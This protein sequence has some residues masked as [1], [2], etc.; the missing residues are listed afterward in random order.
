MT[1][2]EI[3]AKKTEI[4]K[5]IAESDVLQISSLPSRDERNL[6]GRLEKLLI[7]TPLKSLSVNELENILKV[8][9]NINN[10]YLPHYTQVVVE[11]LN[12]INNTENLS[13][14]ID[15]AKPLP[16]TSMYARLKSII[17]KKGSIQE[18][19]RRNPL[20]Y[21]DQVFGNFKTKNI[22]DSVFGM[23]SEEVSKFRSGLKNIQDRITKAEQAVINSFDKDGNKFVLSKY[24]QMAYMIQEEFLSNPDSKQVN[25]VSDFL[26]AT[27]TRIDEDTTSYTKRDADML[28][29]IVDTYTDANGDFDNQALY[30]SF[31]DAEKKS[32]KTLQDINLE[33]GPKAVYTASIIRGDKIKPLENYVHLNVISDTTNM[34]AMAAPSF[35]ES[36]NNSLR[37]STKAKSLIE[38]TGKVSPLNF[39]VYSSVQKGAKFVLMDYHLTEPIRT[40]RR[41]LNQTEK[42]LTKNGRIDSDKRKVFNAIKNGFEEATLNLLDNSFTETSIMDNALSYIK[43]QGYRAILSSG[44]RFIAELTSNVSFALI[45][46]PKGFMSGVKLRGFITSPEA[47]QAMNNLNSV[48][49]NRIFPNDS[50]SGRMVDTNGFNEAKGTK[51]GKA[52]SSV[53]NYISKLWNKTGQRWVNGVELTADVLISTPDKLIMRPMWFGAFDNRFKDLTGKSPDFDKIAQNDEAYMEANKDALKQATELA[54]KRSVMAGATDNAFMGMLKGTS[55]PNQKISI[56]A[57]NAFNNFMTRFL[58]FEYITARSG[59]MSMIGRGEMSKKQGGAV[60]GAVMSRMVLYT[61]IG[62]ILAE[63]LTGMFDGDDEE[64]KSEDS[65][66]KNKSFEK[67]LGQSFASAFSS[68]LF[69]RDFGNATKGIINLGVE[70]FNQQQL[71]FLRDGDYD[72]YKDAIQYT[73]AP[74]ERQGKQT[75]LGDVLMKLGAAYGPVLRTADLIVRKATEPDKKEADAI[76]R[77]EDEKYV[78][79]PLEILGNLG[80]IPMYK[81]IRKVVLQNMYKDLEKAQRTAKDKKQTQLE[82]LQGYENETDMKRYDR[83]LWERTYGPNSPNYDAIKAEKEIEIEKRKIKQQL[84]DEMYDY[85]PIQKRSKKYNTSYEIGSGS[86]RGGSAMG[87]SGKGGS[88]MGGGR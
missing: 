37:P 15:V 41:T 49:T 38:R 63:S 29:S 3:E 73:I 57:F 27:I 76:K 24:K 16:F 44:S 59:I 10:G 67:K 42:N 6:A 33:L 1:D 20:F 35:I 74:M 34:D 8:L 58:I 19:V 68:L 50:L 84:K 71:G 46:D 30:N 60:V 13:G 21:I 56:Q 23:A 82:M 17:T 22:F 45:A 78:R 62:Q 81:D 40:A 69:G 11:Q 31:N 2:A 86:A 55:K 80:L 39:D 36:F 12:S 61:L 85:T 77:Q 5:Q 88:A 14:A 43:K 87:G 28:Q 53:S 54:D 83:E 65:E 51:G 18:M 70:E 75:G 52:K 32:I 72:P 64:D 47:L 9:D 7:T 66:P 4:I 48:Q 26:K 79:I 25:N